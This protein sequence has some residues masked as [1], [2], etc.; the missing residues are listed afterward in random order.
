MYIFPKGCMFLLIPLCIQSRD[1]T[2]YFFEEHALYCSL[3]AR[4]FRDQCPVT[5]KAI[6]ACF[7]FCDIFINVPGFFCH[8]ILISM[9]TEGRD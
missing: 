8:R 1:N 5:F 4:E 3:F 6:I 7:N 9:I 2:S